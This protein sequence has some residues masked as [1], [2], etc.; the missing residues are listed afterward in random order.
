VI[1]SGPTEL[2]SPSARPASNALAATLGV[3]SIITGGA[4]RCSVPRS[5]PALGLTG[6]EKIGLEIGCAALEDRRARSRSTPARR[7]VVQKIRA[8]QG[9]F[10]FD[11]RR[12]RSDLEETRIVDPTKV[13][14]APSST[15]AASA[16]WS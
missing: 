8:G 12:A 15:R 13:T 7:A 5:A 16:P 4:W 14:A 9:A 6:D 2:A 3:E 11:A 1:K 10:G